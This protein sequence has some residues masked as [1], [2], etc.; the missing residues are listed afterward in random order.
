M[1]AVIALLA[2][3]SI[4]AKTDYK[5]WLDEEVVWIISKTEREQFD[6]LKEDASREAF[7]EEFWRRRDPTPSTPR[8]EYKEE[9]YRRLA[10]ATR[11]F[12]EGIPGW[13]T[14]R[15]RIYILHGKPDEEHFMTSRSTISPTRDVPFTQRSPNTIAWAYHSNGN[16]RYYK[17]EMILIFQP[18][19]GLSRQDFVL[20]ES[21]TAQEKADQLSRHFGPAADQNWMEADVRY[22]LIVAGPPALINAKGAELPTSGGGELAKYIEDLFRSPGEFVE[23]RQK[24]IDR[25]ERS[26][27]ELRG[28]AK[29]TISYQMLP[30]EVSEKVFYRS[31]GDWLIPIL[32]DLPAENLRDGKI[33]LYAG[34]LR[35]DGQLFDEF[36]DSFEVQGERLRRGGQERLHYFNSFTAPSG[37]Y[38]LKV[39]VREADGKRFG[40]HETVLHLD[41]A[42]PAKL[43]LSPLMLTNHVEVLQDG[44]SSDAGTLA[45]AQA[46]NV[47]V[48]NG[49]RLLPNP[50]KKFRTSENL[51]LYF[52]VWVPAAAKEISVNANFIQDGQFV[53]RLAP[54]MLG[55]TN[56]PCVEYGTVIPLA[57]FPPGNYILQIQAL[58]YASKKYDIQRSDF[59]V[60][61]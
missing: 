25:R 57:D 10:Y 42:S 40:Y 39:V 9:H 26:K 3:P 52:Q 34:L 20:G 46:G 37:E 59:I 15:G 44:V 1:F 11:A 47:I 48:F 18:T 22:R 56:N 41:S 53:R 45:S 60:S 55:K 28:S 38:T 14:D 21:Q 31:S 35:P 29:S 8:N 16:A 7:I 24:E 58:D 61:N 43:R 17:G 33:D 12:Q 23:E 4:F 51:F 5:K 36:L 49:A 6:K 32:V 50:G 2:T 13:K 30:V 54:R 27:L 19:S